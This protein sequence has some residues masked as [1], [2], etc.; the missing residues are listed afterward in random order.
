MSE[1]K[2]NIGDVVQLKSGGPEMTVSE[3]E[4]L[5]DMQTQNYDKFSGFV[6]CQWF[7]EGKRTDG[8][9]HQDTLDKLD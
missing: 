1:Q 3:L 8:K 6:F 9:F 4:L 7:I 5:L 2:L